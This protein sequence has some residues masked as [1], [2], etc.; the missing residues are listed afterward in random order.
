MCPRP[1]LQESS[2]ALTPEQT[3]DGALVF[4]ARQSPRLFTG[5]YQ[6]YQQRIYAYH[7]SRTGNPNEAE[8]LTSQTFLAALENLD[9]YDEK[10]SFA[11]WLF[12]IAHHKLADTLRKVYRDLPLE[13]AENAPALD[14]SP[15]EQTASRLDLAAAAR[16]M[17]HLPVDQAE[18]LR[19][20]IFA[21]L[22]AAQAGQVMGKSEAAVKML[23]L[24]GLRSLQQTLV[25]HTE[26]LS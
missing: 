24:R 6:R 17:E 3:S 18:T 14:P 9:H 12:G 25:H 22:S 2:P 1:A 5:L 16:G 10:R 19:L 15:E 7:L 13:K 21:G 23:F 20:R 8:E 4:Q 26:V 11:G